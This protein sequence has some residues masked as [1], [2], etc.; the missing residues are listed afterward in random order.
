MKKSIVVICVSVL[1]ATS[2]LSGNVTAAAQATSASSYFTSNVQMYKQES[3][4]KIMF[5]QGQLTI[6]ATKQAA[7]EP[8]MSTSIQS[9]HIDRGSVG[10]AVELK[11]RA[12]T[13]QS[14]AV[15]SDQSYVAIQVEKEAG[16]EL[17]VVDL[18]EQTCKIMN[19][20]VKNAA[21]VETVWA[22]Q[23]APV[24][25][26]LAFAYGNTSLSRVALYNVST[27]MFTY[28]PRETNTISTAAVLWNAKGSGVDFVSEYPSDHYKLYR[29]T[30]H[31]KKVK[32]LQS[33][34]RSEV[35]QLAKL[36]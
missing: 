5:Q 4:N 22:Y 23:W 14:I 18:N 35:A 24:G 33:L 13:I 26:T 32:V 10:F 15:S 30:L 1:L 34:T 19:Q 9:I 7:T 8:G 21:S 3:N 29:Y 2:V 27:G 20:I 36:Q 16:S 25:N 31:T 12:A 17:L 28:V 11:E 6:S